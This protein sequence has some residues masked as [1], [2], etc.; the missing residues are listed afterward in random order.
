MKGAGGA[1]GW[2]SLRVTGHI[3]WGSVRGEES[4]RR[5]SKSHR[6]T[7]SVNLSIAVHER[8]PVCPPRFICTHR[9]SVTETSPCTGVGRAVWG[10]K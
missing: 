2:G 8:G 4:I 7:D 9:D 10:G 1:C 5:V 3:T 6:S